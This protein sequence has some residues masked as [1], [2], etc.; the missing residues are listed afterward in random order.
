GVGPDRPGAAA[1]HLLRV[2]QRA[3]ADDQC[4]HHNGCKPNCE[5]TLSSQCVPSSKIAYKGPESTARTG[6]WPCASLPSTAGNRRVRPGTRL[7]SCPTPSFSDDA[8]SCC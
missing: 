1:A 5:A 6:L 2:H 4:Q 7:K 3:Q 8:S